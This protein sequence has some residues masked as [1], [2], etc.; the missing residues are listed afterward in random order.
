M[1][2]LSAVV[3]ADDERQSGGHAGLC[4]CVFIPHIRSLKALCV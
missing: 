4:I 3:S 2:D 1:N